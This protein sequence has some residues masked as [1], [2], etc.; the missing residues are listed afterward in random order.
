MKWTA[1]IALVALVACSPSFSTGVGN[2]STP[3]TSSLG[4]VCWVEVDTSGAP[5]I[6]TASYNA[7]AT[8]DVDALIALTDRVELQVFGRAEAP[9]AECTSRNESGDL[10]LSEPF[11]LERRASQRIEVGGEAYGADLADL[12]NQGTFWIGASAAG[13]VVAGEER[14]RFEEGR[15]TVG[16]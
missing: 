14:V 13:N 8:Y 2:F 1:A 10:P 16:F 9:E 6:R 4:R 12:V 15:I 7:T 11:E 3:I 5:A